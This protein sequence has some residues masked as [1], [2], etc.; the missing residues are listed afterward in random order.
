MAKHANVSFFIVFYIKALETLVSVLNICIVTKTKIAA[1]HVDT[2]NVVL[3]TLFTEKVGNEFFAARNTVK[4]SVVSQVDSVLD[5]V[6]VSHKV[7]R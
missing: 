5:I 6:G 1:V 7:H 3:K 2:A 4:D